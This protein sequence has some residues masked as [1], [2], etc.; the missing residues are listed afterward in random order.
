MLIHVPLTQIDDNPYQRRQ[1]Y[2]DVA[3]LADDIRARGLLQV[4][5]G[6]L[7]F[8]GEPQTEMQT[9]RALEANGPGWP[10]GQSFRVQLAF[11]HRRLRAYRVL[12]ETLGGHWTA[13]PVYVEALDDDA[14]LDAVWSENQHRSDINPIEQAEL[15]AEKLERARAAGGNQATVAAEWGL[16][17]ST[18]ANKV[19]LLDLP[20]DV[21]Q[22]LRER[23]LSERQAL[24]LLSVAGLAER[25]NGAAVQWNDNGPIAWRIP[26]PETYITRVVAEPDKTTSDDI[27]KYVA[28]AAKHAGRALPELVATTPVDDARVVQPLCKGC[29]RRLDQ[30]CLNRPCIEV[31]Q[32]AI[33]STIARAKAAELGLPYSDDPKHFEWFGPWGRN[34]DLRQ[35]YDA[36]ITG[37]IV[38]GYE[39]KGVGV[40]VVGGD[41]YGDPW[42]GDGQRLAVLGHRLGK[43]TAAD[44]EQLVAAASTV[45]PAGGDAKPSAALLSDWN[46]RRRH[47]DQARELRG[48]A[49]VREALEDCADPRLIRILY[50]MFATHGNRDKETVGLADLQKVLWEMARF[51][52]YEPGQWAAFLTAAGLD[53]AAAEAPDFKLRLSEMV[54]EAADNFYQYDSSWRQEK[55]AAQ[56]VA[57]CE[58]LDAAGFIGL[59]SDIEIAAEWLRRAR[60]AA[61]K[62]LA[63]K[64]Q[65][66]TANPD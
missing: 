55:Y 38:V 13:M 17:R 36:G 3:A 21:Q 26:S 46:K 10:A 56:V 54:I 63:A 22:A 57:A 41:S 23:R 42:D 15:L 45:P 49:A 52:G 35:L 7:L 31:K 51:R 2:G 47:V 11:G 61:E 6:R 66:A 28:E 4:P 58:A 43:V 59:P 18:I 25:L 50:A 24:A 33:A 62:F 29:P 27:R 48:R 19:R 37:D 44:R 64:Q 39:F 65:E 30:W 1:D 8:D 14:M 34:R 16:D 9:R 53:P 12:A 5:R 32:H 40:R 20:A 60:P